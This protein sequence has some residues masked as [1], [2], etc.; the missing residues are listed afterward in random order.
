[1]KDSLQGFC[2]LSRVSAFD[3]LL[4]V[5][6]PAYIAKVV[7]IAILMFVLTYILSAFILDFV[8]KG[9]Y[10]AFDLRFTFWMIGLMVLVAW[11]F[12]VS[13]GAWDKGL[14]YL[15]IPIPAGI[16][17]F[18]IL[19]MQNIAYALATSL[20]I[21][22]MLIYDIWK[23]TKISKLLIKFEPAIVLKFST[24]GLL[25]LFA[26]LAGVMVMA[27]TGKTQD[28]NIG[29]QMADL[30][31]ETI[32]AAIQTQIQN[33]LQGAPQGYLENIDP[34][35]ANMLTQFGLPANLSDPV[36]TDPQNLGIDTKEIVE[37]QVNTIIEPYKNFIKP[38]MAILLF[39]LLR[40]YAYFAYL[41]FSVTVN[42]V[43]WIAKRTGFLKTEMVPV[44]KEIL[45]F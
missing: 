32:D 4:F 35:M 34:T 16:A 21:I 29:K 8:I 27:H 39:A 26:I 45:K 38:I 30:V 15:I 44:Q 1:M 43:Y 40:F 5:R 17:V 41:I 18:L 10:F 36:Y 20:L 42:G 24:N 31:G 12:S 28:F 11:T 33:T 2:N 22:A 23:S 13:V 25:L 6:S 37:T 9:D 19:S 7:T 3:I 14:Q